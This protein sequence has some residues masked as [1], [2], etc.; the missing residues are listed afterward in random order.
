[1]SFFRYEVP[2]YHGGLPAGYAYINNRVAGTP[3]LVDGVLAAGP[4]A[5]SYFIGY[6]EDARS[7]ATNRGLATLA[8]NTDHL[9]D[10]LHRDTAVLQR[11][12]GTAVG[13]VNSVTLPVET[14]VGDVGVPNTVAGILTFIRITDD[15]DND[16]SNSAGA[17]VVVSAI[18]GAA[19]GDGFST[20]SVTATISPAIPDGANYRI[21]YATRADAGELP[22]DVHVRFRLPAG[23]TPYNTQTVLRGLH[24]NNLAW[25][26]GWTSTIYDLAL[27]G[28]NERYSR[29]TAAVAVPPDSYPIGGLNLNVAGAGGWWIRTGPVISCFE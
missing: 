11:I 12:E 21:Y 8:K 16:L 18:A 22:P 23:Q 10:L 6:G 15:Q 29:A 26:A 24:G 28:I 25:N 5:G 27:S 2:T 9:D 1:M 3:A 20:A 7:A 19:P 14:F 17:R 13:P 4:H